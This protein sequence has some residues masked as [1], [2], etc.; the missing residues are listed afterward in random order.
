MQVTFSGELDPASLTTGN[1]RVRFSADPD[2]YDGDDY[3]LAEQDGA[4]AWDRTMHATFTP[5]ESLAV[6][7]Y[8]IELDG[9]PNGIR[10]PAGVASM[11]S[12]SIPLSPV[13]R[14]RANGATPLQAMAFLAGTM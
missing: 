5:A 4:V 2:F 1:F 12:F 7:Y 11:G 14:C 8:L 6:G 13:R 9:S 10:S 3:F